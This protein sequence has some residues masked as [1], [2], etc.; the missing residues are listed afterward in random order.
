M[1]TKRADRRRSR[2]LGLGAMMVGV[3]FAASGLALTPASAEK[4]ERGDTFKVVIC[5]RDNND[6]Q[7]Y[8]PKPIE[9]SVSG[10]DG[11]I[12]GPD[13]TGHDGPVWAPGMKADHDKWGDIIP[14]YEWD[15]GSFPGLN[16]DDGQEIYGAQCQ[17]PT[18]D[19]ECPEDTTWVDANQ[20]EAIDEGECEVPCPIGDDEVDDLQ[21]AIVVPDDC[22]PPECPEDTTWVDA[23]QNEAIDEGE[24]E[25]PCPI[26]DDDEAD[27]QAAIVIPDE[28]D[29]PECPEGTTWVDA[30]QNEA[31]D[32]GECRARCVENCSPPPPPPPP[33]PPS[34]VPDAGNNRCTPCPDGS[35][36]DGNGSCDLPP[37]VLPEVTE[38]PVVPADP[39]AA[40][41]AEVKGEVITRSA[42]AQLPRTGTDTQPLLEVGFGLILLGAGAMLFGRERTALS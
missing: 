18:D 9:V 13:H 16:W 8:G 23:N 10:T 26:G 12:Q 7:P 35:T 1:T 32:E 20:N 33:P 34:C 28:C 25:V 29:P 4:P 36:P 41:V 42:P 31:I 19:P 38:P 6:A 37:E 5:H 15:G 3:A 11:S 27:L 22:D 21:A 39:P 40:P 24:C 14:P 17:I 30:N 2:R